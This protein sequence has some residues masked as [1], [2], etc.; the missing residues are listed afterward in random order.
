M[1]AYL[2]RLETSFPVSLS[3]PSSSRPVKVK[4]EL[5]VTK[6]VSVT[7]SLHCKQRDG[8][9]HGCC[10]FKL[11]AR[12]EANARLTRLPSHCHCLS[13]ATAEAIDSGI[14]RRRNFK[15]WR[16]RPLAPRTISPLPDSLYRARRMARLAEF[17]V[18]LDGVSRS[19]KVLGRLAGVGWTEIRTCHL[20][21]TMRK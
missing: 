13:V 2:H 21:L 18:E 5:A 6:S 11:R 20:F 16:F 9:N 15:C 3:S 14:V 17:R 7:E 10:P 12:P 8:H 1:N 19:T 4:L